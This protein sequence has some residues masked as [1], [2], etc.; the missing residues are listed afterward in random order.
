M[1]HTSPPSDRLTS[2]GT[3]ST[4]TARIA[5]SCTSLSSSKTVLNS[6]M[7]FLLRASLRTLPLRLFSTVRDILLDQLGKG[8]ADD[9]R[10]RV[11]A[12]ERAGYGLGL[13]EG[14]VRWHR[15]HLG[16]HDGLEDHGPVGR[17]SLL[18]RLRDIVGVVDPYP[19]ESQHL[20]PAGVWNVG[21]ILGGLELGVASVTRCSQVT[22]F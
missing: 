17:E 6:L 3:P 4:S 21:K 12:V 18:P 20:R 8:V 7:V 13:I 10:R 22:K 15:R 19:L 11:P 1:A 2:T 14:D 5:P 16:V 9:L